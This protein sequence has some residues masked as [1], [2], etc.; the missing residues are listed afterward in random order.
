MAK[1]EPTRSLRADLL[2]NLA[3]Q[4]FLQESTHGKEESTLGLRPEFYTELCQKMFLLR[5]RLV[6]KDEPTL[7]LRPEFSQNSPRI[8][9]SSGVDSPELRVDSASA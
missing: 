5:S 6:T 4:K 3:E 9:L 7:G 8:E 1:E 2:Q